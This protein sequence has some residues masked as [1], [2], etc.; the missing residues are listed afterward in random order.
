MRFGLLPAIVALATICGCSNEEGS[1]APPKA[2]NDAGSIAATANMPVGKG[3]D[4]YVLS[5]SWSPT[6]CGAND[7][8]GKSGQCED[9]SGH[10]LIV[11]GLWPQE[12]SGYP[13]YA[14][15]GSP[16]ACRNRSAGNISISFPRWA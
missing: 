11:H 2:P 15:P 5:L 7:P 8:K 6:W 16:T 1:Q 10:G 14:G 12:E 4:F 3:F 13:E 9:G